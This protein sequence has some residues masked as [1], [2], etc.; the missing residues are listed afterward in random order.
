MDVGLGGRRELEGAGCALGGIREVGVA[1][2]AQPD[3]R[4]ALDGIATPATVGAQV[5]G[6]RVTEAEVRRVSHSGQCRVGGGGARREVHSDYLSVVGLRAAPDRSETSPEQERHDLRYAPAAAGQVG[7]VG[8]EGAAP[9][10]GGVVE[11]RSLSHTVVTTRKGPAS[12]GVGRSPSREAGS[13]VLVAS[14]PAPPLPTYA[15]RSGRGIL[16]DF[17]EQDLM[18]P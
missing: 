11:P 3:V 7:H 16:E 2:G 14:R 13:L 1:R 17:G 15:E 8:V 4:L 9:H 6:P 12:E 5:V 18:V 10:A